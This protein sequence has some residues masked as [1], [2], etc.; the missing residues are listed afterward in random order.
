MSTGHDKAVVG[1]TKHRPGIYKIEQYARKS[2]SKLNAAQYF[3]VKGLP[4]F[5]KMPGVKSVRAYQGRF[6]F[7][8]MDYDIEIW[9]E[10]EDMASLDTWEDYVVSHQVEVL[11]FEAEWGQH[12]EGRGSRLMGDWPDPRWVVRE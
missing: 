5:R 4:Y 11:A 2:G 9:L 8:S 7:G 3:K 1:R 12:F 6:G 10:L